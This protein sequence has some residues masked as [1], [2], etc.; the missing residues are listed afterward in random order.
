MKI[1]FKIARMELQKLFFS[2]IAWLILILFS[3]QSG[4]VLMQTLSIFVK[5]AELGY[6]TQNL[7]F[8]IFSG[9]Y[10]SFF[11]KVL[12]HLYLYIPLL[13]MGLIS[14]E[15]GSGSIKLLYS[16]PISNLQIVLGKFVSMMAFGLVMVI[17]LFAETLL[18]FPAIK[19]FDFP[20]ILTGLFGAYLVICT[21]AAIGLF[22]SSLTSYQIV[23]AIGTFAGLSLLSAVGGLWQDIAFVRDITYWLS[24]E[25]R[26]GTLIRGLVASEDVLYFI[27]VS[28]LFLLFTLFR[29]K[30]IREKT[31]RQTSFL[32][33]VGAF[34]MVALI[35]YVS[36]LPGIKG[37]YDA[38]RTNQNTLTQN[39]QKVLSQLKGKVK[40]TTYAN[41]F[42]RYFFYG[43]P[44]NQKRDI[45]RY[46]Q[47]SRFYPN[48]KF[49]Y[50]FYY[51]LP[52]DE[53]M[54]KDHNKRFEGLTEEQALNKT[55]S[56]FD[57][58]PDVFKRAEGFAEEIDLKA[59]LYSTV[60]TITNE[61]GETVYLRFYDDMKVIPDE[62][63]ITAAFKRLVTTLPEVG[64]VKGHGE[65]DVN[66]FGSRGYYSLAKKK[67]F[68]YAL[69]NN[70]FNFTEFELSSPIPKNINILVIADAKKAFSEEE[71]KNL[72]DY[73][74]RGGN[75][76]VAGDLN[77]QDNMNPIVEK[78]GVQF[79]PGQVVEHNK[80]YTMDLITAAV[81]P[82]GKEISY[83]FAEIEKNEAVVS[84]EGAVGISYEEKDGFSYTP[85]LVSDK[86]GTL[87][88]L[89]SVGSWNELNPTNFI[90]ETPIYTPS[91][92]DT[93][94]PLTTALALRRKV[95]EK[96]QKIMILGDADCLSNAELSQQRAWV[97]GM[98]FN[99]A[100]GI[101]FWLSDNEVPIDVRRPIPS[102]NEINL[103][104]SS[105]TYLNVLYKVVLPA[106]LAL[107]F[108]IVWLRRK[109][110]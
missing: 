9:P 76:I 29:L 8:Q 11:S 49:D 25:G 4:I 61:E 97:K 14:R 62:A 70:G 38:T 82:E 50:N 60:T 42:D 110:R 15:F 103:K 80:G 108:L 102:D 66:D 58:N 91:K 93:S 78:L 67:P 24:I 95:D 87:R 17:I 20:L 105:L 90:D 23:A 101:F 36:A 96:E 53:S 19:E 99:M 7:T 109:G 57:V 39:S 94:G 55:S 84:M 89:D 13:T 74:D 77:R 43:S 54:L 2:P 48:M 27:L 44:S 56:I 86:V 34:M 106:V 65:R 32:R 64:F 73:I 79:M 37:Y 16:S 33:Y 22:M 26:S 12:N 71:V 85:V 21:Y 69:V 41:I 45:N 28:A 88:P 31:S 98:N 83:Q 104:K 40:V 5:N 1:I 47:Y 35:G 30:A 100:T 72:N 81:T 46:E 68:R 6:T 51:E 92:G 63:Q 75:L 10:N 3:I 107:V 52:T 59:E 18:G